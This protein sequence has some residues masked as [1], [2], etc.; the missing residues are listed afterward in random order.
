MRRLVVVLAAAAIAPA[1]LP[2]AS[3][4]SIDVLRTVRTQLPAIKRKTRVPI[5]LPARLRLAALPRRVYAVGGTQR[6]GWFVVLTSS[7]PCGANACFVA[8]FDG[9][10]GGPLPRPANVRLR[11]GASGTYKP[12]TCGGSCSPASIWF[13]HAGVLHSWQVKDPPR[14]ARATLVAMANDA[15]AAGPR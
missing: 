3:P 1:T 7:R 5:L 12:V 13:V 9:V 2:A 11:D 6:R 10:R 15:I 4:P 8:S 14:D